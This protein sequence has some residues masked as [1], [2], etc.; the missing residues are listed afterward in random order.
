MPHFVHNG[1]YRVDNEKKYFS[2]ESKVETEKEKK[3]VDGKFYTFQQISPF[4]TV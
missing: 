3:R 4:S 1:T 2:R